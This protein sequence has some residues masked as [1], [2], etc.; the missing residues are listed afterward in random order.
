M[1]PKLLY[2]KSISI[3]TQGQ[4]YQGLIRD[5]S[6]SGAFIK[7]NDSLPVRQPIILAFPLKNGTNKK[8]DG[9]VVWK[10]NEVVGVRFLKGGRNEK[11]PQGTLV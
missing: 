9:R 5:I 11:L 4:V 6:S 2:N 1:H 10:N 8:I 3:A 7:T